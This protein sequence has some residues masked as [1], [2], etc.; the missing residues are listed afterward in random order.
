MYCLLCTNYLS[1]HLSFFLHQN[2]TTSMLNTTY[3]TAPSHD[4]YTFQ[5]ISSNH[6]TPTLLTLA[7]EHKIGHCESS[8]QVSFVASFRNGSLVTPLHGQLDTPCRARLVCQASDHKYFPLL[9]YRCHPS[10]PPILIDFTAFFKLH[11]S[12]STIT[13]VKHLVHHHFTDITATITRFIQHINLSRLS[14]N[15]PFPSASLFSLA[16]QTHHSD[17]TITTFPVCAS[18]CHPKRQSFPTT[19]LKLSHHLLRPNPCRAAVCWRQ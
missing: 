5:F 6:Y 12:N 10:A 7:I 3:Q 9:F 17:G 8:H 15:T 4:T 14:L 11:D 16:V 19:L 1:L 2:R 18:S 13:Q